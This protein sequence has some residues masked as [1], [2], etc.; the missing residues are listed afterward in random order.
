MTIVTWVGSGVYN[1]NCWILNVH[2]QFSVVVTGIFVLIVY[3]SSMSHIMVRYV[4]DREYEK[5]HIKS[6]WVIIP[7]SVVGVVCLSSR[8]PQPYCSSLLCDRSLMAR[9][10]DNS[11]ASCQ[12]FN[13]MSRK[14]N[15]LG[16]SS[17]DGFIS[18]C[19]LKVWLWVFMCLHRK[20]KTHL[21]FRVLRPVSSTCP[22]PP[23][24]AV[25]ATVAGSHGL[26]ST[27]WRAGLC[28]CL[29]KWLCSQLKDPTPMRSRE[30]HEHWLNRFHINTLGKERTKLL[31]WLPG[32]TQPPLMKCSW[33][34]LCSEMGW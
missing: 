22:F 34:G 19:Q 10:L 1:G 27:G 14:A 16:S 30:S 12:H 17:L 6:W 31:R 21:Q 5:N 29:K 26:V 15:M 24:S 9:C 11:H 13:F 3:W 7:H 20:W 4:W 28:W 23:V 2:L 18:P 33:K 25:S 8:V 32:S